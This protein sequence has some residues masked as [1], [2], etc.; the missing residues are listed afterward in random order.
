DLALQLA[1]H[2]DDALDVIDRAGAL[3]FVPGREIALA[4]RQRHGA[5][6]ANA[7]LL[8]Q[9][10]GFLHVILRGLAGNLDTFVA[11]LLD[12]LQRDGERLGPHPVMRRKM[13]DVLPA[14][15]RRAPVQP[16]RYPP[17]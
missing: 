1:D 11:E 13:H 15:M 17:P 12:A 16:S 8:E 9:R 10:A 4:Q 3:P 2:G 7:M 14:I 5:P 6:A